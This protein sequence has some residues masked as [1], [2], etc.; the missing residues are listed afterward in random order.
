MKLNYKRTILV[1]FAFFLI[2][3][4]WQAYDNTVPLILTNK[5]GMSQ[6]WSGVIMALDNVLALF[7]LPLFGA[8]SDKHRG[9]RGRRTPFIVVG[10]LI[11]AVMLIALSFVD[12][13]Q[14]RHL[15]DVSA[16]DD[17][18]ALEQ[19]YGCFQTLDGTDPEEGDVLTVSDFT[20]PLQGTALAG[21]QNESSTLW[22]AARRLNEGMDA[23]AAAALNDAL[24][25]KLG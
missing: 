6:A 10:T 18:A 2:C 17:P 13:A 24:W 25:Q 1:G 23:D 21:L 11:A 7:M 20:L 15:S 4:F 3:A 9:K 16:I 5:F 14:L 8:I 22:Y 19:R 12:S